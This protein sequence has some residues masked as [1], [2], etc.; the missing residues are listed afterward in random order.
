MTKASMQ[1]GAT[2]GQRFYIRGREEEGIAVA[3]RSVASV[4][5]EDTTPAVHKLLEVSGNWR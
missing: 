1:E 2:L 3:S 5:R 4:G